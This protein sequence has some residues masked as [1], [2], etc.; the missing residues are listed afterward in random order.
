MRTKG[1]YPHRSEQK[2]SSR[3]AALPDAIW[4]MTV[5]KSSASAAKAFSKAESRKRGTRSGSVSSGSSVLML[6]HPALGLLR[7]AD[8]RDALYRPT[9]VNSRLT[10][11]DF[12]C[13]LGADP[14]LCER[15]GA[16]WRHREAPGKRRCNKRNGSSHSPMLPSACNRT[17]AFGPSLSIVLTHFLGEPTCEWLQTISETFIIQISAACL[18]ATV[19]S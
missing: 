16:A 19:R 2:S 5:L 8:R 6:F 13:G 3:S 14:S 12:C 11:R 7:P 4:P 10:R 1:F 15:A 17:V 18:E 9:L